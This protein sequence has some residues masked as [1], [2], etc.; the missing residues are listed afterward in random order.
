MLRNVIYDLWI[1]Y[2]IIIKIFIIRFFYK[3]LKQFLIILRN[4]KISN[5]LEIGIYLKN[6]IIVDKWKYEI[7]ELTFNII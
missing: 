2:T 7:Y 1:I 5:L 3:L 6:I 4:I